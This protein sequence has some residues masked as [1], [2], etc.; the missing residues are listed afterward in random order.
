MARRI[1]LGSSS[2]GAGLAAEIAQVITAAGRTP[3]RWDVGAFPAGRTLLEQI[4]DLPY[5]FD[6]AVLLA[7]PDIAGTRGDRSFAAPAANVVFEY[8]YLSSRLTRNRVAVCRFGPAELP[9][10][11]EGMKVIEGG[12]G[13]TGLSVRAAGELRFWLDR[14][15]RL[16]EGFP[17][18]VQCHGYSGRWSVENRFELWRGLRIDDPDSIFYRGV[19][20]IEIPPDGR[21][22]TGIMYGATY[23]SVGDYTAR[24]DTINEIRDATAGP[25]GGL[26]LRLEVVRRHLAQEDGE[27]PDRRFRDRMQGREFEVNLTPVDGSPGELHGRHVYTRATELFSS[28]SERYTFLG[29]QAR[30]SSA[31]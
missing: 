6:G 31:R 2:E 29:G 12:D 16:A 14:L 18:V 15:V 27:P 4:E 23:V 9:S 21:G 11:L 22:G 26:R 17:A 20:T 10:D 24:I 1:F 3:V 8:G 13:T 25:D 28:A 19:A 30:A 5:E 7:T